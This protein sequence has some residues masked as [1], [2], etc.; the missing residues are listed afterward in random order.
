MHPSSRSAPIIHQSLPHISM[1]RYVR[2]RFLWAL[3]LFSALA[4]FLNTYWFS[5]TRPHEISPGITEE[6]TT[7]EEI[8][9]ILQPLTRRSRKAFNQTASSILL[10]GI[11]D[12]QFANR[13]GKTPHQPALKIHRALEQYPLLPCWL[14]KDLLNTS[15]PRNASL[16][17][18]ASLRD[19][20]HI[21]PNFIVQV[22]RLALRFRREKLFV[23]IYESSSHDRTPQWLLVLKELLDLLRC[24]N[25]VVIFGAVRPKE[26]EHSTEF[27]A[28]LRN[29][30]LEPLRHYQETDFDKVVIVDDV[31]FC[32]QQVLR[33]YAL[34]VDIACAMDYVE[35]PPRRR[36][37][38]MAKPAPPLLIFRDVW[39]SIDITGRHF[40]ALPPFVLDA[41]GRDLLYKGKPFPVHSCSNGLR[42]MKTQPLFADIVFRGRP[43]GSCPAS[44]NV[45]LCQD[46]AR[47]GFQ[48]IVIDPGVKVGHV[49]REA[50]H[51][52]RRDCNGNVP[53]VSSTEIE[54][55]TVFPN[56]PSEVE[57][58]QRLAQENPRLKFKICR[59]EHFAVRKDRT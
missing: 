19:A 2:S 22:C 28:R 27:Y 14:E 51:V 54:I 36:W 5:R 15:T 9:Q 35:A 29:A 11:V 21:M 50:V 37:W 44:E 30:A 10:R 52:H 59:K 48:Q 16:F 42:V 23:S 40:N 32:A 49:Y 34:N 1:Q 45:L 17:F 47:A 41:Y 39:S 43:S 33:L 26:D 58:C 12:R 13:L 55:P 24:P 18:A 56:H 8:L 38:S 7:P 6:R 31:F 46:Y 53:F 3:V 20:E 4:T 57:C 25:R